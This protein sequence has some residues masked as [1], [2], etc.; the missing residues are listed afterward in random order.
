M[1]IAYIERLE[2]AYLKDILEQWILQPTQIALMPVY[3]AMQSSE[4]LTGYKIP[5]PKFMS[6]LYLPNNHRLSAKLV[7]TSV[8]RGCHVVSVTDP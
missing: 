2:V 3:I 1:E 5:W 6:K 8:E 7:P 4:I